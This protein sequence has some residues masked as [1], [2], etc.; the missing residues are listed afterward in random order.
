MPHKARYRRNRPQREFRAP[1][2]AGA[3]APTGVP[4]ATG[5][6]LVSRTISP[7]T[8]PAARPAGSGQFVPDYGMIKHEIK[9]IAVIAGG[10]FV[11]L[12]VLSFFLR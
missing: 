7:T 2:T 10:V 8:Y 1:E 12:I 5:A 4:L 6:P 11:I 3:Q 9:R